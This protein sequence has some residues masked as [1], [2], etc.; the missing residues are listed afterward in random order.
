MSGYRFYG[1]DGS[2]CVGI[3]DP[4]CTFKVTQNR[5]ITANFARIIDYGFYASVVPVTANGPTALPS[6]LG[7][8][9]AVNEITGLPNP[10]RLSCPTSCFTTYSGI[11]AY[12]GTVPPSFSGET[13]ILCAA[14]TYGYRFLGWQSTFY[15]DVITLSSS[16]FNTVTPSIITNITTKEERLSAVFDVRYWDLTVVV[17][18]SG[19]GRIFA[20]NGLFNDLYNNTTNSSVTYNYPILSGT[21]V[22]IYAS[23]APFN[24]VH[25][26]YNTACGGDGVTACSFKMNEHRTVFVTISSGIHYLLRVIPYGIT[27]TDVVTSDPG[28]IYCGSDC[29]QWY[30]SG[31]RVDL[32]TANISNTCQVTAF[33]GDQLYYVY[34]SGPGISTNP[35][36]V[37][38]L[39]GE[40]FGMGPGGFS[41][42]YEGTLSGAPYFNSASI[43]VDAEPVRV[44]ML[45]NRTVS[46]Q[47]VNI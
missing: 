22:N 3:Y 26:I 31:T 2:P 20:D 40:A 41:V 43:T 9:V 7:K 4:Y 36:I 17:S 46:A 32:G 11:Q 44:Y 27:C 6:T 18:G 19:S 10:G 28:G 42:F 38:L 47:F 30:A 35:T 45:N 23:A 33:Y 13:A 5:S 1:F 34:T 15:N 24:T 12:F 25:G 14:P 16:P 21:S 37:E 39:S 29:L 8:I